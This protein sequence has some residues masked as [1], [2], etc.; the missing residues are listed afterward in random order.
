MPLKIA[1]ADTNQIFAG[2]RVN[3]WHAPPLMHAAAKRRVRF[4]TPLTAVLVM[5]SGDFAQTIQLIIEY[6]P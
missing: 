4:S 3:K 1:G 6:K 2:G 5:S